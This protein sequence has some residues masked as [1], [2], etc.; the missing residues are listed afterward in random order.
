MKQLMHILPV[1]AVLTALLCFAD[2]TNAVRQGQSKTMDVEDGPLKEL[3]TVVLRNRTNSVLDSAIT[4]RLGLSSTNTKTF[5]VCRIVDV[6]S[7]K[8][9]S[10]SQRRG[11]TD[12]IFGGYYHDIGIRWFSEY[13]T[14]TS[15][16]LER[17]TT[18]GQP[19]PPD[20]N[21]SIGNPWVQ[22]EF[23]EQIGFW[24]NKLNLST[25]RVV[26]PNNH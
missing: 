26:V 2:G 25:N 4:A 11:R 16:V 9:V 22:T 17:T 19:H 1:C 15:G 12:I 18:R 5:E 20:E 3:A 6:F 10:V 14:S 23:R 7:S 21:N 24:L 8:S 13:L